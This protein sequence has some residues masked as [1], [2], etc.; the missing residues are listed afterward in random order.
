MLNLLVLF[1]RKLWETKMSPVRRHAFRAIGSRRDVNAFLT[2]PGW[3]MWDNSLPAIANVER[4]MPDANACLAYKPHGSKEVPPIMHYRDLSGKMLT[5]ETFNETWRHLGDKA[6]DEVIDNE[7]GLVICH[8]ENGMPQFDKATA[9]IGTHVVHIPHCAE[10]SV[11]G[12]ASKPWADREIDVLLTGVYSP[13]IYPFRAMVRR[14]VREGKL[15]GKCR[16]RKHPGYRKPDQNACERE[17]LSYAADLGNAKIAIGCPSIYKYPLARYVESMMAGCLVVGLCPE[18]P[19]GWWGYMEKL[20]Y[21]SGEAEFIA[22]VERLSTL[23]DYAEKRA[24]AG[25]AFV[26]EKFNQDCYARQFVAAV[27]SALS[28]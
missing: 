1:P 8:H 15:P 19:P 4:I 17:V 22:K 26:A 16:I 2:G 11:F 5:I 7:T 12:Q 21:K 28:A 27:K 10:A 23:G 18:M 14:L 25:Q 20:P 3:T 9:K 24:A 6:S 13:S